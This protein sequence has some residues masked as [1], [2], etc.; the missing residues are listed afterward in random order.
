MSSLRTELERGI[1]RIPI[2]SIPLEELTRRRDGRRRRQRIAAAAVAVLV[3][4]AVALGAVAAVWSAN[5][6]RTAGRPAVTARIPVG[7]STNEL[8]VGADSVW[9]YSWKEGSVSRIDPETNTVVATIPVADPKAF[10]SIAVDK[11]TAWVATTTG[12]GT[13]DLV[14]IDLDTNRIDA[15]REVPRGI[16][17]VGLDSVWVAGN[18]AGGRSNAYPNSGVLVRIDPES[19]ETIS[20]YQIDPE[21]I[22]VEF[23]PGTAWV[24]ND[25]EQIIQRVDLATGSVS[26]ALDTYAVGELVPVGAH[27]WLLRCDLPDGPPPEKDLPKCHFGLDRMDTRTEAIHHESLGIAITREDTAG[28][29]ITHHTNFTVVAASRGAVWALDTDYASQWA[30]LNHA[31]IDHGRLIRFDLS[32]DQVDIFPIGGQAF[33]GGQTAD[34]DLWVLD[35]ASDHVLRINPGDL[36]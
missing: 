12:P 21:P 34:G 20:T 28:G 1:D 7:P 31:T 30:D 16:V 19:L 22:D 14:R 6:D 2:R 10:G 33:D 36:G 11:G 5:R 17:A 18:T 23:S 35:V 26:T 3:V 32:T 13:S 8:A 29:F 4:A 9:T 24:L 25:W 27:L 15:R